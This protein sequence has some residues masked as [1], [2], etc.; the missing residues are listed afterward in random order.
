[1]YFNMLLNTALQIFKKNVAEILWL[2]CT[3][4][5]RQKLNT[6]FIKLSTHTSESRGW[7]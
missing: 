1:M 3:F 6:V 5:I 7:V 2:T 4:F